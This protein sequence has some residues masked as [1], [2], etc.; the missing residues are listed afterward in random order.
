MRLLCNKIN[1]YYAKKLN[2]DHFVQ[3][4]AKMIVIF[5]FNAIM[6]RVYINSCHYGAI[7]AC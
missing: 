7:K 3:T 6:A 2:D 4:I 5:T 1:K